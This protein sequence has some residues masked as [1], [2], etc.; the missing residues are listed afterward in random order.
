MRFKTYDQFLNESI[1]SKAKELF[2]KVGKFFSGIGSGFLNL[3]VLQKDKELPKG[4]TLYPTTQDIKIL[5]ELGVNVSAPKI[6]QLKESSKFDFP[7]ESKLDEAVI[8]TSYPDAG[9][10]EDVNS[11]ELDGF[12]RD[13]VEGGSKQKPLLI[14]GAPGIGKTAIINAIAK[15][16]FGA[17]AKEERR[18]ID[19][20]LMLRSPEDFQMPTVTDKDSKDAKMTQVPDSFLPVY[21][22]DDK[23][24]DARVNGPDGKGGILFFDE[25]ARCS[26]KVQNVCLK[27]I[28]ERK[29]GNFV[30]GSKWVIICAANRKSD[31]TDDEQENFKWSSTLANRFHQINY[32]STLEDW[33]PWALNAKDDLGKLLI[34]PEILAF[35][36]FNQNYF[37]LLDPED[38][39]FSSGG[40]EA[41]PSPRSWTNASVAINNREERY[42]KAKWKDRNGETITEKKWMEEQRKILASS[43]GQDAASAFIGFQQ[44]MKKIN[45]EDIKKIYTEPEKAP[46]WKDLNVDQKYALIA[47]ACFQM[48]D[49]KEL[50]KDQMTNFA[51]W[52]IINK[53]APN[54]IKAIAMMT[55][56]VPGLKDDDF[57]NDEVWGRMVDAFPSTFQKQK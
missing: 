8:K 49:K 51:K 54:A 39:S 43:V 7:R 28:D 24:G 2:K 36:K 16:Y 42:E 40:S 50:T 41:W 4:I 33:A 9:K 37:H 6:P 30:L 34:K 14:W 27:I 29:V 15:E 25:L 53:D 32:A 26:S 11:E 3:L 55:E 45:P 21:R 10:I 19:F 57:W 48:K 31:L 12:I 17:N 13:A 38:F 20:D 56:V 44:L 1:L 5:Q 23:D 52:I 35:L 22:I 47:S 18:M 46:T